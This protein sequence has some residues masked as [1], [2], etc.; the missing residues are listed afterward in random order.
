MMGSCQNFY[1]KLPEWG[2]YWE[3]HYA[4][5]ESEC[6]WLLKGDTGTTDS[7]FQKKTNENERN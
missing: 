7:D 3:H 2:T 6:Y 4:L 5:L 1:Q